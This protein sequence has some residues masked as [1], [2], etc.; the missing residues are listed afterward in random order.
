MSCSLGVEFCVQNSNVEA[1]KTTAF[2]FRMPPSHLDPG[3][4]YTWPAALED[5]SSSQEM[6]ILDTRCG[7]SSQEKHFLPARLLGKIDGRMP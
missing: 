3:M 1:L 6:S 4:H 5:P 7:L 2:F